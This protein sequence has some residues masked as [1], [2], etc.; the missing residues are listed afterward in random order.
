MVTVSEAPAA[1]PPPAKARDTTQ[2]RIKANKHNFFIP[3]SPLVQKVIELF[4]NL[5]F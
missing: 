4:K 5:S 3:Y 1:C 2:Q